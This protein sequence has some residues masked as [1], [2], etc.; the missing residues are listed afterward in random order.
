MPFNHQFGE[1]LETDGARIY[2]ED[3]G[4]KDRP[5]LLFLHGGL[6]NIAEFNAILPELETKFRVAGIDSRGHGK[7][8]LGAGEL[9]YEQLQK[10]V[11]HVL[12]HLGVS[13]VSIIGFSD[14]GITGLRLAASSSLTMENLW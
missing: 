10:D 4:R 2:Y 9:T 14:G 6:G 11:E 13:S 3:S 7:S 8:T 5:A 12:R 1:Y